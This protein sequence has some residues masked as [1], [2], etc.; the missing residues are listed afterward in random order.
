MPFRITNACTNRWRASGRGAA[1]AESYL[2]GSLPSQVSS[3]KPILG[4]PAMRHS[5]PRPDSG[6][7]SLSR[8]S[9]RNPY[10]SIRSRA[11]G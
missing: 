3:T 7:P 4:C 8:R 9:G 1:T 10:S 11:I 6:W 2:C 5:V